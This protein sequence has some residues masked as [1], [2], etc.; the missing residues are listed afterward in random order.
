M[1]R[2]RRLAR[3]VERMMSHQDP[4]NSTTEAQADR[5]KS[6]R[7]PLWRRLVRT[8]FLFVLLVGLLLAIARPMMPWAVRWYVNRTLDKS[9]LYQGRIGD[10]DLNL[11]RGAYSIKDI[12]LVK[13]T[14]NVPVP[15]FSS[16]RV[17]FAIQWDALLHQKVVGRMLMERPELN[18]VAAHGEAESQTGA[19][20]PWLQIIRD[21]FPFR[22]NRAEVR[23]GSVHF[24]TYTTDVPVD[25]Y[26][27]HL[28]A[29]VDNLTN[30]D[31]EAAPMITTVK[32]TALAMD[33]ARFEYQMKLD[34]FSYRPTFHMATRLLGLDVTKVND[35]A[36][37]YGSFDFHRG[38]FDLVIEVDAKEG[39]L[40]GYVKPLFRDLKIFSL[41]K[42]I[43]NDNV[44]EFF[45]EALLG[46][47]TGV[48]KNHPRDQFGTLIPFRGDA[49][50]Q[51][52]TDVMAT[53]GN[54]LRNAFVR[55]YLP[56]LQNGGVDADGLEFEPP[57][58]DERQ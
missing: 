45:W 20:G 33:Q 32:A 14:G 27:S 40:A 39:Q 12:R 15:L 41:K 48:V 37:A 10:V 52:T 23:D 49:G 9:Q 24:R 46:L 21:L 47:A 18:F 35:L 16:P 4:E 44:V 53:I 26:L 7:R 30:I 51:T 54:V 56:R 58:V 17:E 29:T 28:D 42:D 34:P 2:L 1:A 50:G 8:L 38:W 25:V 6:R 19:G 13:M 11:W 3:A 57:A 31:D 36:I 22:I 55:A 5:P 43:K